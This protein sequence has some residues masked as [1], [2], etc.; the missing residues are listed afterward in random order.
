MGG[1]RELQPGEADRRGADGAG[2]LGA[3]EALIARSRGRLGVLLLG[4]LLGRM[5]ERVDERG[6]LAQE[7][8]QREPEGR[9]ET[10]HA[11]HG[12]DCTR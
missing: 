3:R 5:A 8:R 9:S 4:D 12:G 2:E 6:V 10:P 7:K 11:A 1:E